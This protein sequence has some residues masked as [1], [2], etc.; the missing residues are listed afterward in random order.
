LISYLVDA[1]ISVWWGQDFK[2]LSKVQ[3]HV[4]AGLKEPGHVVGVSAISLRELAKTIQRR[5]IEYIAIRHHR[6]HRALPRLD[7]HHRR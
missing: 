7:A 6:R 4:L 3:A 5:R 1:H 2:R